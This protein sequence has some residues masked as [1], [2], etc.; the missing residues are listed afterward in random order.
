MMAEKKYI[1]VTG[2]S[3]FIGKHLV[4]SLV[5]KEYIVYE[6]DRDQGDITDFKFQFDRI[7]HIVHLASLI[8]IPASWED[9]Q[10]FYRT[11]VM[12][13]VN[14]LEACRKYNCSLTYISSYVYGP[15]LYLPVDENHP[16][17]PT[18]PYNHSK[19][20]AENICHYYS[21][22]FNI[23][24]TIFRPVNVYGPGQ[25]AD[26]LIPKIISQ[27]I[28]PAVEQIEVMDLRP[29]RDYLYIDDFIHAINLS[30]TQPDFNI[31]NISSG[32]SISVE[33]IIITILRKAG[34]QKPYSAKNIERPNEIWDVYED[35]SRISS[36]MNWSPKTSF[37][38][39]IENIINDLKKPIL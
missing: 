31:F 13:V 5:E 26:F 38:Q 28:D 17:N 7:D 1:L 3:G 21:G 10:S 6:F 22:T 9:P 25:R 19:L 37:E 15:P 35:H 20:V 11:N 4:K 30:F 2:S 18:S 12:G 33:D 24:V 36:Q 14:V 27:V 32:H 16:V 8:F 34:I 29:K 39:G 23:P